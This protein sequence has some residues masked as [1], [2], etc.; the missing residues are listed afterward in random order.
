MGEYNLCC[1][2]VFD[3][4]SDASLR[5]IWGKFDEF[6]NVAALSLLGVTFVA[7]DGGGGRRKCFVD[8]FSRRRSH[9]SENA[10]AS[11]HCALG[12]FVDNWDVGGIPRDMSV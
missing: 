2:A 9:T 8:L 6:Y 10:A 5:I 7:P 1:A 3:Y 4:S 12:C 11:L